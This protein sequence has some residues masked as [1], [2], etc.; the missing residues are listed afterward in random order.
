[1]CLAEALPAGLGGESRG[2][3][4]CRRVVIP[5]R[6]LM[7]QLEGWI[8]AI[9]RVDIKPLGSCE[10]ISAVGLQGQ[11]GCEVHIKLSGVDAIM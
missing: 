7:G 5:S 3:P 4:F 8:A 11:L 9:Q 1:M 10:Y 2:Q 6:L